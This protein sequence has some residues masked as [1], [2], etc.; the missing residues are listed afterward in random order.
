MTALDTPPDAENPTPASEPES[1]T[2]F[3]SL[4]VIAM[5]GII[6]VTV[7]VIGASHDF[8]KVGYRVLR[9]MIGSGF[10]GVVFPCAVRQTIQDQPSQS[11]EKC[12]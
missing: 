5:I 6:V 2:P 4:V 10:S 12:R 1:S 9:N 7:A 8:T 3:G 11:D